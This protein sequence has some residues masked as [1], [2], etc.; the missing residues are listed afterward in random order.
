M[1]HLCRRF[2]TGKGPLRG[3][4]P[5]LSPGCPDRLPARTKCPSGYVALTLTKVW[6]SQLHIY[7]GARFDRPETPHLRK[8]EPGLRNSNFSQSY[9]PRLSHLAGSTSGVSPQNGI[10]FTLMQYQADFSRIQQGLL[11]TVVRA[12]YLIDRR[13]RMAP[14]T[15]LPPAH[16]MLCEPIN[17]RE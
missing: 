16:F 14:S 17:V 10:M 8:R 12:D 2:I 4:G 15:G 3:T 5:A 1:S 9:V 6:A 11:C 13:N 7:P